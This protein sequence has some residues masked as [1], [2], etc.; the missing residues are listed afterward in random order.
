VSLVACAVIRVMVQKK[1]WGLCNQKGE[2]VREV[3]RRL[4][5]QDRRRN[6][7]GD[8][9]PPALTEGLAGVEGVADE[10][11]DAEFAVIRRNCSK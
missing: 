8:R 9:L 5:E 3:L 7:P 1:E 10:K 4:V 6:G 2:T 11:P